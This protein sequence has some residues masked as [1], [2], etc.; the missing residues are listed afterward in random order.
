MKDGLLTHRETSDT[1]ASATDRKFPSSGEITYR[2]LVAT[3][4]GSMLKDVEA[5]TG[6]E[7]A[8]KALAHFGV[9][10]KVAHVEPAPKKAD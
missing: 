10:A 8:V 6:D 7:A 5:S 3:G 2:V 4:M 9:G 1:A